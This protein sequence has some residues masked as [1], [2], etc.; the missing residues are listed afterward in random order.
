MTSREMPL[1]A[2]SWPWSSSTIGLG[3]AMRVLSVVAISKSVLRYR[4]CTD[5]IPGSLRAVRR[6][7]ALLAVVAGV[8]TAVPAHAALP[9]I[10][11]VF[12]IVLENENFDTSFGKDSPAKY[13]ANELPAR[14]AF[15]PEY[16][17]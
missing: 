7:V 6:I 11:H 8:T 10:K 1:R 15:V 5:R 9:P 13:L 4:N 16:F 14:G 3:L 2:T 17:G 12:V